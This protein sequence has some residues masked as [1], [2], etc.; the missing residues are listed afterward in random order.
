MRC[1]R[2]HHE[3]RE[4]VKKAGLANMLRSSD[5]NS[6]EIIAVQLDLAPRVIACTA[7]YFG[8]SAKPRRREN[9]QIGD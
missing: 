1:S 6:E 5:L 9:N 3:P 8:L 2:E 7:V 4:K